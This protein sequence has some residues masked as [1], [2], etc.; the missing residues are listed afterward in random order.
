MKTQGLHDLLACLSRVLQSEQRRL[1][2][3]AGLPAVQ[4]TILH[5]LRQANR[6]SNT[7][8]ALGEYLG[9]AGTR[10]CQAHHAAVAR[11]RLAPDP[12]AFL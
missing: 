5:Y 2:V 7:P 8:L 10:Q 11:V 9:E 6:Y 12:P 3:A 4:W 1:A